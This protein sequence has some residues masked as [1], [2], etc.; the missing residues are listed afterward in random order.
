MFYIF[1]KIKEIVLNSD[2]TLFDIVAFVESF[3]GEF[4]C[5]EV[6][7]R[8]FVESFCNLNNGPELLHIFLLFF[9]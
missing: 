7:W 4:I 3:Y 1:K 9:N 2:D 6:L 8:V 5:E